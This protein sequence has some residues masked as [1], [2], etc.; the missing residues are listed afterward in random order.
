MHARHKYILDAMSNGA[1]FVERVC[2]SSTYYLEWL[3]GRR[4]DI[5]Q[6]MYFTLTEKGYIQLQRKNFVIDGRNSKVT[7]R[8]YEDAR[9]K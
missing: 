3:D 6:D 1:R 2:F 4:E 8:Y 7:Y 9:G 5:T